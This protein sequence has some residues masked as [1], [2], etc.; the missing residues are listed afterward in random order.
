[1]R[2]RVPMRNEEA[3]QFVVAKKYLNRYGAKGLNR[4]LLKHRQ[5]MKYWEE[6]VKTTK[7]FNIPKQMIMEAYELVKSNK[8]APGVDKQSIEDFDKDLKSNLYK[9][10]NRM[11]AGSYFPKPVRIVEIPKSDGRKRKLGIP[12]IT[13]RTA[14]VVAKLY[15]EPKMEKIFHKNS[16]GY[17]PFKSATQAVKVTQERCWYKDWVV[18]LDIKGFFDNIDHDLMMKAVKFHVKEKWLIL[19]IERWLKAPAMLPNG[20]I[21]TRDKGTPQ[22]GV[23]SPLLANLFLHYAFDHWISKNYSHIEFERY[24]DDIIIHCKTEKQCIYLKDKI[25]ERLNKCKLELHPEKTKIVY[26]KDGKRTGNYENEKFNFL[27]YTFR[28]RLARA[29]RGNYF[30]GFNPAVSNEAKKHLKDTIKKFNLHKGTLKEVEN[31]AEV[32]NPIIRGWVNY[33][34]KFNKT[35]TFS[36]LYHIDYLILTWARKRYKKLTHNKK[37]AIYWLRN[38]ACKKPNLFAH[39]KLGLRPTTGR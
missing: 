12:T 3:D 8:G 6:Q 30:V 5:P 10:W 11:S 32:L 9:L 28:P 18:D 22:G 39:W 17:R 29:K 15:L 2:N 7:S 35:E 31:I 34:W 24:A 16:Y 26:C 4:P 27:G 21:E 25:K 37:K 23:I 14:Q 33:F 19:Y 1:V 36:T 13:D 20:N 38:V